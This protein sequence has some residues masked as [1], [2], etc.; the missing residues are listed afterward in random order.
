M[1]RISLILAGALACLLVASVGAA[2]AMPTEG[3]VNTSCS[4]TSNLVAGHKL[5][6]TVT[7]KNVAPTQ[8]KYAE[9]KIVKRV[10]NAVIKKEV[11]KPTAIEGFRITPS[12][13]KEA[14]LIIKYTGLFRG[15]DTATEIRLKFKIEYANN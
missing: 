13:V 15:A 9:C 7:G 10:L 8:M 11:E 6:A 4:T 3:I 12:I 2:S 1:K 14:P 5:T